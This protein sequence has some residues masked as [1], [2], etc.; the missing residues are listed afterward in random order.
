LDDLVLPSAERFV[1]KPHWLV[2]RWDLINPFV[3][4]LQIFVQWLQILHQTSFKRDS[5]TLPQ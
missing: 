2:D 3:K 1:A 4:S 5:A